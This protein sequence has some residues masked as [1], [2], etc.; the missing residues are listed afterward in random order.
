MPGVLVGCKTL[1]LDIETA[2]LLAYVW[3]LL[4]NDY[5]QPG[6]IK[7]DW[8]L[9]SWAAKWLDDPEILYMDQRNEPNIEDDRNI[10]A[11]IWKLLDEADLIVTQNG[12]QF[13]E[14]KL[15]ARFVL[16]GFQPPASYR[17][18]DTKQIAKKNFAF[19]SNSLEYLSDKL[20][21]QYKK[22]KHKKFPGM[23]LWK[24]CLARNPE[25]WEEME[26][27]NK[28]D[29]LALEELYKKLRPWDHSFNPNLYHEESG[30]ICVCGSTFFVK[31][32]YHLTNAG[33]F[34]R[35]RCKECGMEWREKHNNFDAMKKLTLKTPIK[36]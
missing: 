24:E 32:G 1:L 34:D 21:T 13:D 19:S 27:Y 28:H 25:A 3:Q 4:H 10:L 30:T 31:N 29:V 20:C 18:Q 14:K 22:L 11:G 17:H 12:K 35:Y 9:L 33:R 26:T 8:H 5:I 7:T 15:N 16:Q 6:N 23:E 36:R 2:P